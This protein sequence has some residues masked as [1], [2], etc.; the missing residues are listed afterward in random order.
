M[1]SFDWIA[2]G[3]AEKE[4]TG[5]YSREA[6]MTCL[7]NHNPRRCL[8]KPLLIHSNN[9]KSA[10]FV[11]GDL[12]SVSC[13][14]EAAGSSNSTSK[15]ACTD[16]LLVGYAAE[17]EDSGISLKDAGSSL[18]HGPSCHRPPMLIASDRNRCTHWVSDGMCS[19]P[20][21]NSDVLWMEAVAGCKPGTY[22]P[23]TR[24]RPEGILSITLNYSPLLPSAPPVRRL[25]KRFKEASAEATTPGE[26][27]WDPLLRFH[28]LTKQKAL[29]LPRGSKDPQHLE[30]LRQSDPLI[31]PS[32]WHDVHA[33]AEEAKTSRAHR[34][35]QQALIDR[36][37]WAHAYLT[38]SP[39]RTPQRPFPSLLPSDTKAPWLDAKEGYGKRTSYQGYGRLASLDESAHLERGERH[40]NDSVIAFHLDG[41]PARTSS[42]PKE[43]IPPAAK[44]QKLPSFDMD[45]E[46]ASPGAFGERSPTSVVTGPS[47]RELPSE[48]EFPPL[49]TWQGTVDDT[50]NKYKVV[51]GPAWFSDS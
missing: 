14:K 36:A 41:P 1:P 19:T 42:M 23:P 50:L 39:V 33:L 9:A 3:Y 34:V 15:N 43:G 40:S 26:L 8:A 24:I 48:K 37:L 16:F 38:K 31:N 35:H 49:P 45:E 4:P 10:H 6:I 5:E 28:A 47:H 30:S 44:W 13:A 20:L 18:L 12:A 2:Q 7:L 25:F 29:K 17:S 11:T 51:D 32:G 21:T 27:P 22:A 46:V